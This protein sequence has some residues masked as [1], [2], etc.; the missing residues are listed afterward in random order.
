MNN[1]HLDQAIGFFMGEGAVKIGLQNQAK[2]GPS[3]HIAIAIGLRGDDGII[4]YSMKELFGGTVYEYTCPTPTGKVS[5]Q[6]RWC[7]SKRED[8]YKFLLL[9]RKRCNFLRFHKMLDVEVGIRWCEWR[10]SQPH[11]GF[12]QTVGLQLRKE[13]MSL[14]HF[15]YL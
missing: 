7:L 9:C 2:T 11:H 14:H 13:L 3:T 5:T 8:V 10:N 15:D 4:L 12:D 1:N 6:T